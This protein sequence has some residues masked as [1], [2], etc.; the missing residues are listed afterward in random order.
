[1]WLQHLTQ[2]EQVLVL[3]LH[4]SDTRTVL[5][6]GDGAERA[7][8]IGYA[9]PGLCAA[10][11]EGRH[12]SARRTRLARAR[13]RGCG[14]APPRAAPAVIARS[15]QDFNGDPYNVLNYVCIIESPMGRY[16]MNRCA[17]LD[18]PDGV[19]DVAC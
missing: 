17:L 3:L 11:D 8:A 4:M 1:M 5:E 19:D 6:E 2:C 10:D 12:G 9:A 16:S 14:R 13:Q 15:F 18:E 7:A